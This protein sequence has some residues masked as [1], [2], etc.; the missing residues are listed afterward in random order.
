[1]V[2]GSSIHATYP[3]TDLASQHGTCH[4]RIRNFHM[5]R[6]SGIRQQHMFCI[7]VTPAC[8]LLNLSSLFMFYHTWKFGFALTTMLICTR[9]PILLP[10][11][12][13]LM[14]Q[15]IYQAYRLLEH[16]NPWQCCHSQFH[17]SHFQRERED[18]WCSTKT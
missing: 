13:V 12:E 1:M 7:Q 5:T 17:S 6:L 2:G 18:Y 9:L 14:I 3:V 15:Y 8:C 4:S 10:F 16:L 11:N